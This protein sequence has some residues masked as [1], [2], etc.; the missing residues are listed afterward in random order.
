MGQRL[1][2]MR[3][4]TKLSKIKNY[5]MRLTL[6]FL[7]LDG[8]GDFSL[9]KDWSFDDNTPDLPITGFRVRGQ[10]ERGCLESNVYGVTCWSGHCGGWSCA[11]AGAATAY[12]KLRSKPG[13][14][15]IG[16]A[17]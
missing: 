14:G 8:P 16:L 13:W 9:I 10:I 11:A 17:L 15:A 7:Q 12:A 5:L 1:F 4:P 6:P 3:P 2:K